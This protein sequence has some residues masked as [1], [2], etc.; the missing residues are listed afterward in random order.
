MKNMSDIK[1]MKD[2][3]KKHNRLF[4][5]SLLIYS[6]SFMVLLLIGLFLF[7]QY[8]RSY[9]QSRPENVMDE[10]IKT[11]DDEYMKQLF[12]STSKISAT[13]FE[14][15][16]SLMAKYYFSY[17]EGKEYTYRKLS[18]EYT[19]E[20]PTYVIRTGTTD[21]AKVVLTSKGE[22][23]A[24]YDFNLWEQPTVEIVD[25]ILDVES[26][27]ISVT[28]PSDASVSINGLPVPETYITDDSV[29]YSGME[30]TDQIFDVRPVGKT[31]TIENIYEDISVSALSWNN[32]ELHLKKEDDHYSVPLMIE[33]TYSY[34][35]TAPA[36]AKVSVNDIELSDEYIT[37]TDAVYPSL[38]GLSQFMTMPA[39][40]RY[41]IKGLYNAPTVEAVDE[42]GNSLLCDISGNDVTVHNQ[43]SAQLA[44]EH[45][46]LVNGFTRTY[47]SFSINEHG[48]MASSWEDFGYLQQYLL[49]GTD[50]YERLHSAIASL[51]WV[52]YTSVEYH[53][54]TADSFVSI[55]DSCFTCVMSYSFTRTIDSYKLHEVRTLEGSFDLVYILYNG[56]WLVANMS[57]N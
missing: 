28:V 47:V 37:D 16:D 6:G 2:I 25:E 24:G 43:Y 50:L 32:E 53:Y 35:I 33:E 4:W 19:N 15:G 10:Y 40:C 31:Y 56:Q 8:M 46:E 54:V 34:A 45:T 12:I 13:E 3:K 17:L 41:E 1:D 52:D 49:K 5:R 14:D 21:I 11:V 27:V 26:K 57:M 48:T 18:G 55:T 20:V 38:L 23:T 44:A 42:N 36:G 9:E 51:Y 29:E 39:L 22:N 7:W 30:N